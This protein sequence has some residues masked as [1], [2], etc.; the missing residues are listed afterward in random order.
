MSPKLQVPHLLQDA[1]LELQAMQNLDHSLHIPK[2]LVG[3][4][5]LLGILVGIVIF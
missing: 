1:H 2:K 3:G 4:H 5:N